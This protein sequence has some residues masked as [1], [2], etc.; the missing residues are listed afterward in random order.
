MKGL[1]SIFAP[2]NRTTLLIT[3]RLSQ[4]RWADKILVFQRGELLD[5]GTHAELVERCELYRRIFVRYE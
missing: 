5:Q 1:L 3:H 4:I 2:A